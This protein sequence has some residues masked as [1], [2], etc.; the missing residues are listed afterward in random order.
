MLL[1][2]FLHGFQ[3]SFYVLCFLEKKDEDKFMYMLED[4]TLDLS[5]TNYLLFCE[6]IKI[7]II[8]KREL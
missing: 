5:V 3:N 8:G 2:S 1:N 4:C 7:E 6:V